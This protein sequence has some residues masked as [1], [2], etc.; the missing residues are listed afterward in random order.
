MS[1]FYYKAK[2][3]LPQLWRPGRALLHDVATK[4]DTSSNQASKDPGQ[5]RCGHSNLGKIYNKSVAATRVKSG[6]CAQPTK[7]AVFDSRPRI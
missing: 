3:L 4:D 7:S 6:L 5:R 2:K 1:R